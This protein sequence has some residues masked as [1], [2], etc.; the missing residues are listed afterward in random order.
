MNTNNNYGRKSGSLNK[1]SKESKEEISK[2]FEKDFME[3]RKHF[4]YVDL[5]KKFIALKPIAKILCSGNDEVSLETKRIIF[6]SLKAEFKKLKFHICQLPPEKKA[7]EL[8]Q[9]LTYLDKSQIDEVM[10][11]LNR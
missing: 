2:L 4:N 10:K 1:F 6:E 3:M 7:V 11:N 8:R 9:Y 5:D